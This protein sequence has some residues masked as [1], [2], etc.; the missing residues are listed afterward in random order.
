MLEH[1]RSWIN[2]TTRNNTSHASKV[3]AKKGNFGGF[4]EKFSLQIAGLFPVKRQRLPPA[5]SILYNHSA[6]KP[7]AYPHQFPNVGV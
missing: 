5:P 6:P 7:Q 3:K 4:L 2:F 1:L